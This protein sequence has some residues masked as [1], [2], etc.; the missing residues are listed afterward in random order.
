MIKIKK[1]AIAA[2]VAIG[3][4][5]ISQAGMIDDVI[6]NV[7]GQVSNAVGARLGDEIYYGSS[8]GH[9]TTTRHHRV[10]KKHR[11]RRAK[12]KVAKKVVK[13]LPKFTDEM[14]IQKALMAL[15]FYNGKLD[16][17]VNSFETRSAIKELNKKYGI[18]N[19]ASLKPEVKDTLIY[20]GTLFNLDR[21]LI[22]S[23][24]DKKTKGKKIQAALK[25]HGFYHDKIDGLIGK[26]TRASIAKY[27]AQNGMSANGKLD[28]EEEY[29]LISSAK[30]KNEKNI[31]ES[32]ASLK[33]LGQNSM[34]QQ[35]AQVRVQ[36]PIQTQPA[37]IAVQNNMQQPMQKVVPVTPVGTQQPVVTQPNKQIQTTQPLQ[38][39]AVN[40]E[41]KKP[42]QIKQQQNTPTQVQPQVQNIQVVNNQTPTTATQPVSTTQVSNTNIQPLQTKQKSNEVTS[43]VSQNTNQ[44]SVKVVQNQTTPVESQT[45]PTVQ[46][47]VETKQ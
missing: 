43:T 25:V 35:A 4:T 46:Q 23:G 20:L 13:K 37:S 41:P 26:G 18:G 7:V 44:N 10:R 39:P 28:F 19:T 17:E 16:G 30:E 14:K 9:A 32:I 12:K 6:Y 40:V 45:T 8:R 11:K 22:A 27:K 21:T 31:E 3:L 38:T 24:T 15:G 36:Q 5:N 33:A 1:I 47:E 34:P 42:T 29:Q 2:A